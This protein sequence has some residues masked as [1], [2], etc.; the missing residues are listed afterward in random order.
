MASTPLTLAALATSAVPG[1]QVFGSRLH[2]DGGEGEYTSAVL[3]TDDGELIVRV[4]RNSAAEV[5]QSAEMLGL[6]ALAEGARSALPFRV[7]EIRGLTRAGD[8]RAVVSTFLAGGRIEAQDLEG[9]ALLLQPLAEA[10]AAIHRLPVTM[11]QQAGLTSRSADDVRQEASRLVGRASDTRLLPE[12]VHSRWLEA[13]ESKRLWD[14]S[15]TVVHGSLDADRLL[16]EDDRIVGV[17]GWGEL[18]VGDPAVDLAWLFAAGQ[19]VLDAVLARY[20]AERGTGGSTEL[21]A[22]TRFH[23]ELEVARWLLH[24]VET[25]DSAVVDDAVAMLD[26]LVDR[27]T[28]LGQPVPERPAATPD[29]VERL[30]DEVPEAPVDPRSETAEYEALDEDRVFAID[31][32]FTDDDFAGDDGEDAAAGDNA[33]IGDDAD[34]G[35]DR[36]TGDWDATVDGEDPAPGSDSD[37]R[38][39]V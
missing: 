38:N 6:S 28:R 31:N 35:D 29:E 26:R 9:E 11:V 17:L 20:I 25:H 3:S 22:R 24:G 13:L 37:P 4:P 39:S 36:D 23:H 12:V 34:T 5:R 14:F 21:R 32:D 7:S 15:P 27:F 18:S 10:L 1:L 33:V 30:L 19:E 8:T 2:T 16:I